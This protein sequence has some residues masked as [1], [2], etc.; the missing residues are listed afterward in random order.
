MVLMVEEKPMWRQA[1]GRILVECCDLMEP[2]FASSIDEAY[3]AILIDRPSLCLIDLFTVNYDFQMLRDFI[4]YATP[5]A[6]IVIVIDDRPNP[7]LESLARWA[8]AAGYL[9]KDVDAEA[10]KF[11]L[12]AAL[13]G[14][15][16][17]THWDKP[18]YDQATRHSRGL[19]ARQLEILGQLTLGR[20]NHEIAEALGISTG[21]VKAH[22]HAVL[23]RIGAR[24]RVHAALIGR[25]YLGRAKAASR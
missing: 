18:P 15:A 17:P 22:V 16:S 21:T 2:R 10:L 11:A 9:T 3:G 25:G 7:A 23:E 12:G 5:C 24:N 14:V 1:L 19:S 6:V 13:D 4:D 20:S 8:G